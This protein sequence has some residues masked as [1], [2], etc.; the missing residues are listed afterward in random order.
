[1]VAIAL[2]VLALAVFVLLSERARQGS[3]GA[4]TAAFFEAIALATAG[5]LAV[6]LSVLAA[7]IPCGG[8]NCDPVSGHWWNTS[9][10][11]QWYALVAAAVLG[12]AAILVSLWNLHRGHH[13]RA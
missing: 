1:M 13:R 10:A 9:N 5:C 8:E 3:N 12:L 2:G 11:W 6:I 7:T 4:Q